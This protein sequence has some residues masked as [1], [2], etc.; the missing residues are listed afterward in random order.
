MC[1]VTIFPEL[2]TKIVWLGSTLL[3]EGRRGLTRQQL[4]CCPPLPPLASGPYTASPDMWLA[5]FKDAFRRKVRERFCGQR[6]DLVFTKEQ[7][8]KVCWKKINNRSLKQITST[9][10]RKLVRTNQ[11]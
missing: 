5:G 4:D 7:I 2:K 11:R 8:Q 10:L 6:A 3:H 1:L 9:R